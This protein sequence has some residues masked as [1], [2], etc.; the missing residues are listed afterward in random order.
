MNFYA[1][2][3]PSFEY[4]IFEGRTEVGGLDIA[5]AIDLKLVMN[6]YLA[7]KLWKVTDVNHENFKINVKF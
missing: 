4:T 6:L 2:F 5:Y 1:V 3:S 7:G